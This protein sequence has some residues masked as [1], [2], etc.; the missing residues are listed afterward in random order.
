MDT[1]YVREKPPPSLIRF[2]TSILGTWNFWWLNH[3]SFHPKTMGNVSRCLVIF[4]LGPVINIFLEATHIDTTKPLGRET[5]HISIE[6]ISERSP[7]FLLNFLAILPLQMLCTSQ[8]NVA[9]HILKHTWKAKQRPQN[10][11][12][13]RRSWWS[14]WMHEWSKVPEVAL[15]K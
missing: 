14:Q 3:R 1:A 8:K 4:F 11:R 5:K 15:L 10:S 12:F 6:T 2:S 13:L 7:L 9:F